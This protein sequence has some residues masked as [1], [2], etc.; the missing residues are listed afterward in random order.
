MSEE[1]KSPE[2]T[3]T[4]EPSATLPSP[5]APKAMTARE[6]AEARR[7]RILERSKDR[8][9]AVSGNTPKK[10]PEPEPSTAPATETTDVVDGEKPTEDAPKVAEGEEGS[11]ASPAVT[12]DEAASTADAVA[13]ASSPVPAPT[14]TPTPTKSTASRMAEM[15]RR[16]YKKAAAAKE[17]SQSEDVTAPSDQAETKTEESKE[18]EETS[19]PESV[20]TTTNNEETGEKKKYMGVIKMRRK[21][22]AE[23]K[24]SEE[25]AVNDELKELSTTIPKFIKPK[26]VSLG[27]ILI[28]LFTVVFLFIVG[29]DVGIQNHV[30]VK[31][32]VPYVHAN[33][34]YVDHGI[35]AMSAF[36]GERSSVKV[37]QDVAIDD[38]Y[39][40]TVEEDEFGDEKTKPA[41]A[42]SDSSKESKIDPVFGVDFDR[43]T[44]GSGIFFTAARFA[45]RIHRTLTYFC[46]VLPLAFI[47]FLMAIPKRLVTNPPVMFLC[48]VI[49]RYIGKHVLGGNIPALDEM[50]EAEAKSDK[51]EK[52]EKPDLVSKDFFSMGKNFVGNFIK[53]NFPKV[54]MAFT[55]FKDARTDMFVVLCGFF[56]GLIAPESIMRSAITASDEL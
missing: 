43:L 7:R 8:M 9:N 33:L 23:K 49:I 26:P 47:H 55:V 50:I 46:Y 5:P 11:E 28:Q 17:E 19:D 15:R 20:T 42:T 54:V 32:E 48:S 10:N 51:E 18:K 6:K 39:M 56:V 24:K 16:R 12:D 37:N 30:V 38:L 36:G 44:Q 45:V 35:G 41:G 31:Q 4:T 27:P 14:P 52:N 53:G 2:E 25:K 1:V 40:D 3:P 22:L 34:S 13:E 21:M 29:F